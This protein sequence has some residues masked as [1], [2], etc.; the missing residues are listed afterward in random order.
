M[1]RC[2]KSSR[3]LFLINKS[4]G[5]GSPRGLVYLIP[6]PAFQAELDTAVCVDDSCLMAK[7]LFL[8]NKIFEVSEILIL[9]SKQKRKS[10]FC[11]IHLLLYSFLPCLDNQINDVFDLNSTHTESTEK[12]F[13][14]L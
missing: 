11:N 3:V 13:S 10:S 8:I 4:P 7:G 5:V 2:R 9:F 1:R 12:V 6:D 14:E